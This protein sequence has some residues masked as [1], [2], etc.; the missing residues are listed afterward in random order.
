MSNRSGGVLRYFASV[1]KTV[2]AIVFL[3]PL[4]FT[5][6]V[7]LRPETE[8][9]TKGNIFFG[10]EL[11][12]ENFERAIAIAPWSLHYINSLIFVA[13]TLLVQLVTV[14]CA[15]YA[16]ARMRF[17]GRDLLLMV[18]LLQLMIPSGV[19]LVQNFRM[20]NTLGLFDTRI[21]LMIP[22]WGSAF[23]VLLLRQTFREVPIELEEAARIDGANL[24]QVIR[25]VYVTNAIPAYLAFALV[26]VSTHWNEFLWPF[27][28]TRS[29]AIRPLTLG[30]NK[31][32]KTTDQGAFYGQL[33]AGT[34]IVIAPL[35]IL[36]LLFQRQ[37]VESFARSGIR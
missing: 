13:G 34:L 15:A 11:T 5:L 1:T 2:I 24:A 16:F 31:L 25:H 7:S 35:V 10:S 32:I 37:F 23:G 19:L 36:F 21:A 29:E 12:F 8:P 6:L 4:I 27:I 28:I 9:V 20:I 14:T 17:L 18:I 33:M 3:I 26:S 30:L 22:Y